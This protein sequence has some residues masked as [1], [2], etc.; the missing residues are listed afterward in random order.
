[1]TL[2]WHKKLFS[3]VLI[4]ESTMIYGYQVINRIKLLI[5]NKYNY[6]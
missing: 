5:R 2:K 1:M 3:D 4:T 6:S